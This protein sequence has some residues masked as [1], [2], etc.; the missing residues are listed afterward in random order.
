MS[1]QSKKSLNIAIF[2][3]Y[4]FLAITVLMVGHLT[5]VIALAQTDAT[6]VFFVAVTFFVL[7]RQ[8][9]AWCTSS[10]ACRAA[11]VT[12]NCVHHSTMSMVAQAGPSSDGP[13]SDATGSEIPVWAIAS[14]HLTSCDSIFAKRRRM[15]SWLQPQQK[16]TQ[17]PRSPNSATTAAA[18]FTVRRWWL[19]TPIFILLVRIQKTHLCICPTYFPISTT[20]LRL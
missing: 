16:H 11:A 19:C 17:N 8:I 15:P 10:S 13:V 18:R 5:P 4:I 2:G 14:E 20:I 3:C 9:M 7:E 6:S 12:H 1:G